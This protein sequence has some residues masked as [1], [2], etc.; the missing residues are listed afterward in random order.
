[1]VSK[2]GEEFVVIYFLCFECDTV[3]ENM[4]DE[5]C[6]RFMKFGVVTKE[7]GAVSPPDAKLVV[8]HIDIIRC[9]D[10]L[11][12]IIVVV[13]FRPSFIL[14]ILICRRIIYGYLEREVETLDT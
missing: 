11:L 2:L 14:S 4:F 6:E 9:V 1:M 12:Y 5:V 3:D 7:E 10:T 13:L 8:S